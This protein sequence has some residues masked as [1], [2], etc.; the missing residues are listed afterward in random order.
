MK[1]NQLKNNFTKGELDPNFIGRTETEIYSQGCALLENMLPLPQGGATKRPGTFVIE[2]VT[3][4]AAA[5]E[6][7]STFRN[8]EIYSFVIYTS[9]NAGISELKPKTV[10]VLISLQ[11][12]GTDNAWIKFYQ[13]DGQAITAT[14]PYY[15]RPIKNV[16]DGLTPTAA[17]TYIATQDEIDNLDFSFAQ[18]DNFVFFTHKSGK[19]AP[20]F[21]TF[22]PANTVIYSPVGYYFP[23]L[24]TD[25]VPYFPLAIPKAD[26]F[27]AN[28]VPYSK[29]NVGSVTFTPSATS[30]TITITTSDNFFYDLSGLTYEVW[31]GTVIAITHGSTTGFARI[32]SRVNNQQVNAEVIV[33]FGAASSSTNWRIS[34]WNGY[35]GFPK[36]VTLHDQRIVWGGNQAFSDTIWCSE[37]GDVFHMRNF[38]AAQDSSTDTSGLGYFGP[39][40]DTDAFEFTLS[41]EY[42]NEIKWLYSFRNLLAG[43]EQGLI[44]IRTNGQPFA[45]NT[46]TSTNE[47]GAAC[48]NATPVQVNNTLF[49]TDASNQKVLNLQ[50]N[51]NTGAYSTNDVTGLNYNVITAFSEDPAYSAA[52]SPLKTDYFIKQMLYVDT[53]KTIMLVIGKLGTLIGFTFNPAVGVTAWS[54]HRIAPYGYASV[55]SIS[56]A[57]CLTWENQSTGLKSLFLS[58]ARTSSDGLNKSYNIEQLANHMSHDTKLYVAPGSNLSINNG[59][60][61]NFSGFKPSINY[62]DGMNSTTNH[63]SVNGVPS[64]TTFLARRKSTSRIYDSTNVQVFIESTGT[65]NALH[66]LGELAVSNAGVVNTVS[67]H[68]LTTAAA[69]A[70]INPEVFYGYG[71]PSKIQLLPVEAGSQFGTRQGSIQRTHEVILRLRKSRGFKIG[72]DFTTM[73]DYLSKYFP[74]ASPSYDIL[75]GDF[76]VH[77]TGNPDNDQLCV[78]H[79]IPFPFTVIAI[80][81]KGVAYD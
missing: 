22:T 3:N 73:V 45:Y 51:E 81:L 35:Y 27:N 49:Y 53:H 26:R 55:K 61:A 19:M 11:A 52:G 33:N 14:S 67:A 31:Q 59:F 57:P 48:G 80:I 68:G 39:I 2:E 28:L 40:A 77:F 23:T 37:A 4:I 12:Y 9:S 1:Y 38:K 44:A 70:F 72:K 64:T 16:G 63:A 10:H 74:T 75:A 7:T 42:K 76:R 24:R 50:I 6:G 17:E 15:F 25:L 34:V 78:L 65:T 47:D 5:S 41:A 79:D 32:T 30:G 58:V 18:K 20:F 66:Y 46:V 21:L 60:Q 69:T 62:M 36:S 54:R 8:F 43:T 13:S 71:F 29:Q 56:Q